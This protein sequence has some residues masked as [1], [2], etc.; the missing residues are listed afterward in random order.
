MSVRPVSPHQQAGAH[1]VAQQ[2]PIG[3]GVATN[4]EVELGKHVGVGPEPASVPVMPRHR[5]L[6]DDRQRNGQGLNIFCYVQADPRVRGK[7][8]SLHQK[9]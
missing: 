2:S 8:A 3:Q 1:Y 4:A 6:G 9:A 5:E 7:D